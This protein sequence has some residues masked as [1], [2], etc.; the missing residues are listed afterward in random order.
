[1]RRCT[2]NSNVELISRLCAEKVITNDRV[3]KTMLEVDRQF[4]ATR[5][6]YVDSPQGIGY[7]V[8][9][10]APHMHA[11]ALSTL[12][13][14]L[15]PGKNALDI[16][17]GS[18][19][20]TACMAKMVAP[21]GKATG[22]DHIPELVQKARGNILRGNP[23]LL[24]GGCL[25][26]VVGDGRKGYERNG[27]YD[28]IHVGA[29]APETPSHLLSQLAPGGRLLIP[30]GPQGGNQ[31]MMQYDKHQSGEVTSTKLMGVI[32]VPLTDAKSQWPSAGL[33]Q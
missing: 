21:D 28:A 30:V 12:E 18:G 25:E 27:P 6:P 23:E 1:M 32:Y 17:S 8:T 33:N 9:I 16:G 3:Q 24:D 4:Y 11:F 10:S 5:C 13:K 26:I 20:L 22:I 14:Q 31:V 19:Y 29:A 2:G 7:A 15:R